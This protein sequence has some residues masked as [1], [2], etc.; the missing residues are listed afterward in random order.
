MREDRSINEDVES[1]VIDATKPL[2]HELASEVAL[3]LRHCAVA[4]RGSRPE[5]FVLSGR[6]AFEPGL[7]STIQE[8]AGV[9]VTFDDKNGTIDHLAEELGRL[10]LS[11]E[12]PS[13]WTGAMGLALR[14][15]RTRPSLMGKAA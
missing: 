2:L 1:G 4:F 15:V 14:S 9:E 12:E 13:A 6:D 8:R 11:N 7:A 3:C 10:E 5:Q